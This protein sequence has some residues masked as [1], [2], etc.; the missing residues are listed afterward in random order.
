M[1]LEHNIFSVNGLNPQ[2]RFA[3][4]QRKQKIHSIKTFEKLTTVFSQSNTY[5]AAPDQNSYEA[6][7]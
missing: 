5:M 1:Y 2:N 4:S 3:E 6:N 7:M